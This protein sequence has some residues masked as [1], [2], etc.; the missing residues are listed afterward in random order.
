MWLLNTTTYQLHFQQDPSHVA[1][2]ILSHCWDPQGEQNL[3]DLQAIQENARSHF[4]V[5]PAADDPQLLECIRSQLSAKI[6]GCCDYAR[7]RGLPYA[8][9]DTCCINKTSSAE[10][11]E[12]VNSMFD[13]YAHAEVCYVFLS[14]VSAADDPAAPRS[15]FRASRWFTRGW[16]LQELVVPYG[17]VFLARD[18]RMVGTKASLAPVLAE[19]TG[20]DVQV[21]LRTRPLHA[22]SVARRMSWAAHRA[23][24]RPE[25]E[26][27]CLMGIFGVRMAVIY[28]EGRQAFVRLQEEIMKRIPDQSLFAWGPALPL[29]SLDAVTLHKRI[30]D[31]ALR[32]HP[33]AYLFATRPADFKGASSMASLPLGD[34]AR[35]LALPSLNPPLHLSTSYGVRTS[36]PMFTLT[37]PCWNEPAVDVQVAVL[38]CRDA[39]GRIAAL[40]LAPQDSTSRHLLGGVAVHTAL[41]PRPRM[42]MIDP[43]V[44]S[45]PR[46]RASSVVRDI[47]IPSQ[48]LQL[49]PDTIE[50][51]RPLQTTPGSGLP[52]VWAIALPCWTL[53]H[54]RDMGVVANVVVEDGGE[55]RPVLLP[56]SVDDRHT[57][58]LCHETQ[59]IALEV[60]ASSAADKGRF[61]LCVSVSWTGIRSEAVQSAQGDMLD[62]FGDNVRVAHGGWVDQW[63]NGSKVFPA[64]VE[65][66]AGVSLQFIAWDGYDHPLTAELGVDIHRF[67]AVDVCLEFPGDS[68]AARWSPSS[69]GSSSRSSS[70]FGGHGYACVT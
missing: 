48:R 53:A 27:Y 56:L 13:W 29:P 70:T 41:A 16:T 46:C 1:Y 26:A 25:D 18:W 12:A 6:R 4:Q 9:V 34:V 40:I 31:E 38:A 57:F 66:A 50:P 24:T 2:A 62:L 54:F 35:S 51:A 67:Y 59:T 5:P 60:F 65:G 7:E 64:P 14:D 11:S 10:L 58:T 61:G 37:L 22:V 28:G 52:R 49:E 23:T 21:L 47:C 39:Y 44:F 42:F 45:D 43:A 30:P 17:N 3:Q 36:L 63:E 15:A 20:I 8:W 33:G 19:V 32:A 69:W 55:M 68:P